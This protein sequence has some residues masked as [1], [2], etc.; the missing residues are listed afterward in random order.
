MWNSIKLYRAHLIENNSVRHVKL[1]I[2]FFFFIQSGAWVEGTTN[3]III[4]IRVNSAHSLIGWKITVRTTG[5][6]TLAPTILGRAEFPRQA[7]QNCVCEVSS[8]GIRTVLFST[9]ECKVRVHHSG[10]KTEFKVAHR[11]NFAVNSEIEAERTL[12]LSLWH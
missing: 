9:P 6:K 7:P 5:K 8:L 4:W 3:S 1:R 10:P 12:K 2:I 11:H